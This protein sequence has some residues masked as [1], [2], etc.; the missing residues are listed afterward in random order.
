MS[1]EGDEASFEFLLCVGSSL[2]YFSDDWK[3]QEGSMIT[4]VIVD[5]F[6]YSSHRDN[7]FEA[8]YGRVF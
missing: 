8:K 3:S 6:V 4:P 1:T 7:I 5:Y 2:S